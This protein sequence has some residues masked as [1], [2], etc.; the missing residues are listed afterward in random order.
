MP[1]KSP[2]TLIKEHF[3]RVTKI[4]DSTK[5]IEVQVLPQDAVSGRRGDPEQCAL[6]KACIRQKIAEGA[7]I[8]LAYSYLIKGTVAT[9]FKTSAVVAREI[10]SFDRHQEFATGQHYKLS[11][12][13]PGARLG[14]PHYEIGGPTGPHITTKP[15]T[16]VVHKAP[17][18]AVV[19]K[20]R[21]ANVRVLRDSN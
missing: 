2:K 14:G 21:T 4:V 16:H 19:P 7:I 12:V 17:V 5:T 1:S 18:H 10:T 13:S 3:P 8:G 11:R 20:A 15:V 6:V 9:R